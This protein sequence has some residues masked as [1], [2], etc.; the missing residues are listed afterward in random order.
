MLVMNLGHCRSPCNE[1]VPMQKHFKWNCGT[2]VA[3]AMNSGPAG[4]LAVKQ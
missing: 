3:L 1:A 2:E 4:M